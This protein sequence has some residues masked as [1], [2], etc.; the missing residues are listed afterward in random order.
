LISAA[1]RGRPGERRC[2]GAIE[3]LGDHF[4]IPAENG[5]GAGDAG[6]LLQQFP[7]QAF[8][9]LSKP[10]TLWTG[11]PEP[12]RQMG[13]QDTVLGQQLLILQEQFLVDE[14]CHVGQQAGDGSDVGLQTP[15]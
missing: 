12:W 5:G 2:L 15:S 7:T 11:Q 13:L 8:A 3:L 10:D 9:D 6:N 4:A 1:M 14:T